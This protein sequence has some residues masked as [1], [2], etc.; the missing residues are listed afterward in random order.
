MVTRTAKPR[1]GRNRYQ[2]SAGSKWGFL[3]ALRFVHQQPRRESENGI[4]VWLFRC[5]CG[6]EVEYPIYKVATGRLHSCGCQGKRGRRERLRDLQRAYGLTCEGV[7]EIDKLLSGACQICGEACS[8]SARLS[9][10]HCHASGLVRGVLCQRCNR[11]LGA[12]K[13]SPEI[14]RS[15]ALYLEQFSARTNS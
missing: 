7:E 11:M 2:H 3:T 12:A 14:L 13:D 15:A 9:V 1:I 10:D 6:N 5:D 8:Q 4:H